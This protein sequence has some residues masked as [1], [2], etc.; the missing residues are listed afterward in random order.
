MAAVSSSVIGAPI[1][2]II[3]VLELTGSY[4]YA[5]AATFPIVICSFITSRIF[6][7]SVFDKQLFLRGVEITKGREQIRLNEALI[8]NY[9]DNNYTN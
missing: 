3:L 6:A 5:I 4:E 8:K 2:A 7:N 9:V 1:T